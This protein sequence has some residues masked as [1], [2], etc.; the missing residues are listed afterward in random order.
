MNDLIL[1]FQNMLFSSDRLLIA[2]AAFI[3]VFVFG[4]IRGGIAGNANPIYWV[5][6]NAGFGRLGDKMNKDGRPKGLG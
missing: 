1:E 3:V 5:L 2:I 4:V 6:I